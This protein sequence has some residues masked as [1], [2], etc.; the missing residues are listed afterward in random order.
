MTKHYQQKSK[1]NI[2]A[3]CLFAIFLGV[4]L[5]YLLFIYL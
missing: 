4:I 5:A 3:D 1:P 2:I